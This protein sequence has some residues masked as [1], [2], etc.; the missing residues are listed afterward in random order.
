M[1]KLY[2]IGKGSMMKKCA[3]TIG[4]MLL[5]LA[6]SASATKI[7]WVS[8]AIEQSPVNVTREAGFIDRLTAEGY[9]V[10]SLAGPK[11]MDTTKRDLA[12][13]YDLVLISRWGSSGDYASNATE[14]ALWNSITT[15]MINMNGYL[16][17]N[18]RWKWLNGTE[19]NTSA[20]LVVVLA[21]DP[22]FKGVAIDEN[23]QVDVLS[24]GVST[25]VTTGSAG[26]GTLVAY[27]ADAGTPYVWIAR[28]DTGTVFYPGSDQTAGGPRLAFAA[29]ESG[30]TGDGTYNLTIEGEKMFLNAVYQMSGATFNRKPIISAGRD[31]VIYQGSTIQPVA[32]VYD[33]DTEA[34][35]IQ[36]S[37]VNGPADA[38]FSDATIL[39]PTVS[40]PAKGA[41]TLQMEVNDG[42][43]VVSDTILV[44]VR[45]HADDTMLS[46]WDF[47]SLPDPNGLV[48]TVGG[49][50]GVFHHSVAGADPNVIAGHMSATAVNFMGLQY[51]E[52]ADTTADVDPNYTSTQTG[53]SV[54]AWARVEESPNTGNPMLIGYNLAGWRFQIGNTNRWNLVQSSIPAF[55]AQY[56]VFS[57]RPAFRPQWQH[58]VGVFDGVNSVMKIYIDGV[59]DSTATMPAGYRVGSGTLPL[60]IGNRA[61]QPFARMWP[62]MV[63]DIKV[64][65]YALSDEDILALAAEGDK[66]PYIT[67]GPDQTVFYKGEPVQMDA[68][69]LVNDGMPN[70]LSLQW[71]VV[72]V[73]VGAELTEVTFDD[74]TDEDPS[75]TFP[76]VP[77]VYTLK[78]AGDDGVLQ[79]E[80]DVVI[81]MTIPT[82]DNVIADGFGHAAD[83]SGPA[84]VPDCYINL[85]DLA[86]MAADWLNCNNP[87]DKNCT[88]PY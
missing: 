83:L 60:Q 49:F 72:S 21:D 7:L 32:T 11:T 56:E 34:A 69:L 51:W 16:W 86:A 35:S 46:H 27:R 36:W 1:T 65:N 84:G 37:T 14:V 58:V 38:S 66:A 24:Q 45:D 61:D 25:T 39:D 74:A 40:F 13:T 63:D 68:T 43:N 57:V 30:G 10:D 2:S 18:N 23:N 82:C 59:L 26:N 33:P 52:V 88:S 9:T 42:A 41:Y 85:F 12:N 44:F 77:G 64:Y 87:G 55:P 31:F 73:P 53:L 54:A 5:C 15:P 50:D 78:L 28:W 80:D 4:M 70:P 76:L 79:V 67:A 81:T 6:A 47:E 20:N 62:G 29:G 22:I 3:V 8:D 75:V 19:S 71:S 17:R 48:D